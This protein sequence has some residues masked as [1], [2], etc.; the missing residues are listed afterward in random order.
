MVG[1]MTK[2]AVLAVSSMVKTGTVLKHAGWPVTPQV[3][4]AT[5]DNA[6]VVAVI[7]ENQAELAGRVRGGE[8]R[9]VL[10]EEPVGGVGV[11]R[12]VGVQ[13][14]EVGDVLCR[15]VGGKYG[16]ELPEDVS[17]AGA[18]VVVNFDE[19][20][21]VADGDDEVAVVLGID[22]GVG[23]SP[24]R[25]HVGTTVGVQVVEFVP[26]PDGLRRV[27]GIVA[28]D[29]F[30]VAEVN[31]DVARRRRAIRETSSWCLR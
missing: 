5:I 18:V 1:L 3:P 4:P 12:A 27:I 9:A 19:P 13:E 11:R 17:G 21:L 23:V 26:G 8:G 28:A 10:G 2:V 14:S 24:V 25:I 16:A 30:H 22:D 7:E 20:I 6:A 15:R 31:D 29:V